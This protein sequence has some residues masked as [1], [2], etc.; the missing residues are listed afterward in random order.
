M[1]AEKRLQDM[2]WLK[3]LIERNPGLQEVFWCH[4]FSEMAGLKP[5]TVKGYLRSLLLTGTLVRKG[6]RIYHRDNVPA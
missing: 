6:G 4:K 1:P 5:E 3:I 2:E